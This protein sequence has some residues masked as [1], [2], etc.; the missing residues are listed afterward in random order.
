MHVAV[1]RGALQQAAAAV[2]VQ[3]KD[4][5][6]AGLER[7]LADPAK[8]AAGAHHHSGFS[9]ANK[10]FQLG[11]LVGGVERQ[12]HKACAQRG[13]VQDQAFDRLFGMRGNA[14]AR[15]QIE[16]LQ[17]I[18]HHGGG[19]VQVAPGIRQAGVGLYRNRVQ[20]WGEG[21]AQGGKK[22]VLGHGAM[23]E[24]RGRKI[25]RVWRLRL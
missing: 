6:R 4:V 18:G 5:L 11:A 3:G 13:Q 10:V 2:L 7:D 9:V 1:H 21:R 19:A 15:W 12:I 16:R 22:I 8:V 24:T 20:V 25:S 14:A 23:Q 17:Q